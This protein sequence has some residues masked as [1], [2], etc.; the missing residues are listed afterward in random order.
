MMVLVS[1]LLVEREG[2]FTGLRLLRS[3]GHDVMVF[4]VMD[5]DELDFPFNGPTRFEGLELPEHAGLQSAGAARR[6]PGGAGRVPGRGPP[7]LRRANDVDY[8]LLRTSQP[9]D[10]AL[11]ALP[12]Q[13]PGSAAQKTVGRGQCQSSDASDNRPTNHA[14]T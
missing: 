8:A 6:I 1:D 14:T 5:D 13:S 3:R 9:L 10:A 4:H 12:E 2:L 11:A 7:R